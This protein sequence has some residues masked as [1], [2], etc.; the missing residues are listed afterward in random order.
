MRFFG[1]LAELVDDVGSRGFRLGLAGLACGQIAT[2]DAAAFLE[3]GDFGAGIRRTIQR[4]VTGGFVRDG[5]FEAGAEVFDGLFVEFLV[6]V[7]RVAG[8]AGVAQAITFDGFGEDDRGTARVLD[9]GL[10][11]VV[12]LERV[13][14]AAVQARELLV[15]HVFDEFGGFGV[16]AKEFLTDVGAA[17]GFKGL[18]FAVDAFV[19]QLQKA[20][21]GVLLEQGVPIAAPDAFDD[22]PAGAAE[23]AFE[24]L[25]DFAVA[26]DRAVEAL[27]VAVDDE[28][29]VV[30]LFAHGDADGAGGFGLVH[31]AIAQK[32]PDFPGSFIDEL[33][34]F[35]ITHEARLV[36]GINGAEAHGN[37][38]E[39]PEILH[40][41]RVGIRG[42]ACGVAQFVAEIVELVGGE[43]AF[44]EGA[45]VDAGGGVPLEINQIAGLIAVAAVEEMIKTDFQKSGEGGVGGDVAA[46]A[47][48]V[49]V[50]VRHHGHRVPAREALDAPFERAVARVRRLLPWLDRVHVRG[51]GANRQGNAV[52]ARP[53]GEFVDEEGGAV[54]PSSFDD[55]I[56]SLDPLRCFARVEIGR[57]VRELLVHG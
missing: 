27:Q 6:L 4:A 42:K 30:E 15:G 39:L 52:F 17:F 5:N 41:P 1:S 23:E 37:G 38:G 3:I 57:A 35:Q 46:D 18:V 54:G 2:E 50:L 49:F 9:G 7:S 25:D 21:G 43:A 14:A 8:F 22:V 16:A 36:N 47:L 20:A 29:Q 44:E 33:A 53:V 10:V 28:D 51:G 26:A 45:R 11:G 40:Q 19:H 24:F 34:A 32:C 55:L 48:I 12:D 56:Q 13:V 31:F